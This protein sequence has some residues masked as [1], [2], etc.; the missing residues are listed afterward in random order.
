M[1]KIYN[2]F[3]T[4]P[5]K[6]LHGLSS[7]PAAVRLAAP[8]GL[9]PVQVRAQSTSNSLF[10]GR[11]RARTFRRSARAACSHPP[12]TLAAPCR[13]GTRRRP[14][15]GPRM[16]AQGGMP[17]SCCTH[18]VA[19]ACTRRVP[20]V[21]VGC[22]FCC[23]APLH[24]WLFAINSPPSFSSTAAQPNALAPDASPAAR[25]PCQ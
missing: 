10:H 14:V 4:S 23:V 13:H 25:R 12:D 8:P 2:I 3:C 5:T 20:R 7:S 18:H 16:R 24:R 21:A 17:A 15:P 6:S 11:A 1:L 9:P 22:T 19:R